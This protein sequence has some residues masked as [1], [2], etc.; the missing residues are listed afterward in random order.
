MSVKNLHSLVKPN[1]VLTGMPGAGKSTIGV[2]LAKEFCLAFV[3]TDLVIQQ[4]E[5]TTLQ[6]I[7]DTHGMDHFLAIEERY[8]TGL[9][10]RNAVIAPGGSVVLRD[11]CMASLRARGIIVFLDVPI[12]TIRTRINEYSR[13]IAKKPGTSLEDVWR[14]REPLYRAT[15]DI[16]VDCH[17]MSQTETANVIAAELRKSWSRAGG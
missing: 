10:V 1:I 16:T 3:D 14:L 8:V 6:E 17:A 13:G 15:A 11:A 2:V 7:I 12:E 9:D 4:N 5:G